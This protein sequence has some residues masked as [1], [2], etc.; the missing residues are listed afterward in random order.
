MKIRPAGT[1]L[2]RADRHTDM[3]KLF[4]F[5]KFAK[6]LKMCIT[7]IMTYGLDGWETLSIHN[8][9]KGGTKARF[10]DPMAG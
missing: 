10:G 4:A 1:K 6:V 5:R 9:I 7:V 2:F 3:T 8:H